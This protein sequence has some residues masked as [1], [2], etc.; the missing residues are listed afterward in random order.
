MKKLHRS[1]LFGWSSFDED[2]NLDFHSVLWVRDGGNVA[3]DPLPLSDHDREHLEQL[4]SVTTIV[5]TNSDHLRD[6]VIDPYERKNK[7]S[8]GYPRKKQETPPGAPQLSR[9]SPQQIQQAKE[10]TASTK[11]SAPFSWVMREISSRG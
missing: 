4:G 10:V 11:S 2:R 6:A 7:T 3:I 5:V 1:D 9:A 8:R